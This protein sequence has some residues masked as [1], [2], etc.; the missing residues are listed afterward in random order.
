MGRRVLVGWF[1]EVPLDVFPNESLDID[2]RLRLTDNTARFDMA[3]R[4]PRREFY[5]FFADQS[6]GLDRGNS[7]ALQHYPMLNHHLYL[8]F[9]IGEPDTLHPANFNARTS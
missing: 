7:V 4:S 9:I 6:L 1:R 3:I 8:G 5:V 2:R